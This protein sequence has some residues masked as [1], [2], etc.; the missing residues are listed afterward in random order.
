MDNPYLTTQTSAHVWKYP[1]PHLLSLFGQ[2]PYREL[3]NLD[4]NEEDVNE[5]TA[6][7]GF[8]LS[9]LWY[10]KGERPCLA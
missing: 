10:G 7:L 5:E 4:I 8:A 3:M 2:P 1:P 6:F 9:V